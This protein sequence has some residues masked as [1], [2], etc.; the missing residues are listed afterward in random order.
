MEQIQLQ[1]L[2]HTLGAPLLVKV[3]QRQDGE[4]SQA[5]WEGRQGSQ[6][7]FLPGGRSG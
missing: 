1:G 4:H 2:S 3:L 6:E 5:E 7:R